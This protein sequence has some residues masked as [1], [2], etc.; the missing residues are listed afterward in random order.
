MAWLRRMW[1]ALRPS[2]VDRELHR[3]LAF[4]LAERVEE[5][6]ARGLTL[7]EATR[8]AQRQFGN[9][10]AQT[11]RTRAMDINA[12]VEGTIRNCRYALRTMGKTPA[13]TL[14]VI[15]TLA[16]GIGANSAVFSAINAVLLRPLAFPEGD[17]LVKLTQLHPGIPE[18]FVAP[19]RL[20]E[21]NRLNS[22][23]R[24]ITGYYTE[25]TSETSGDLP[26][27]VTR[28][29]VSPRFLQVLGIS[30]VIGRNFSPQEERYGGPSAVLLSYRFW[31][32]R[33]G[34]DPSVVGKRIRAAGLFVVVGVMP[35]SFDFPNRDVDLW[36][37][38]PPDAPYAQNREATWYTAIGRLKPGVSLAEAQANLAA[39]QASLGRQFPK[40]DAMK[41]VS[42]EPLKETTV[43]GVRRSLWLLFGA[44]SLLL[45]I[46]CVNIAALLLSRTAARQHETSVR[47]SLGASRVS[48]A[49]QL[50]M[51]VWMLALGG[52]AL[53]LLV[54]AGAA[55]VFRALAQNLPRVHEIGL[56]GSIVVYALVCALVVT[57]ACG[58]AP[59]IRG[60]RRTLA[61]SLAQ[62]GRS[63]VAGRSP[64]QFLLVGVQV[65]LSVTLLAG[66]GLLVRSFQELGRV[67]PGF[68]A[69]H[70]LTFHIS[71]TWAEA[72][73]QPA[74]QRT[75]R[76]LDGL[77]SLP[78]VEAVTTTVS[79][80]GVPGNYA[81]ET[82]TA[83]GRSETEPKMLAQARYVTPEYFAALRIPL[84]A[85]ELCRDDGN[86][87][88][89]MV[90]RT[91]ADRYLNGTAAI[92]RHLMQPVN[93]YIPAAEIRGIVGDA[94]ETGLD[95]VPPPTAYWCT[96]S[97][98]P[99]T[100]FLIR[101]HGEPKALAGAVRQ[102]VHELEP[103]RSVYDLTP[104]TEH[105]SDGYAENRLRTFLLAFFA[106]TAIALAS[107]GLYV[108]LSY[109]VN[110]RQREVALRLA[111]GSLRGQVLRQFL[112]QGVRVAVLGVLAGLA[113]AAVFTRMLT[114]MLFGVSATD[115]A[116]LT[117][118]VV[119]VL[120]V[121][122]AASLFPALRAARVE[123]MQALRDE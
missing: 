9:L 46:A 74:K 94:R 77:R 78:G 51:E 27:K 57:L 52:A 23:L 88:T 123:P 72:G 53:G 37:T 31:Q 111:L 11:E 18:P 84:V 93:P 28:A 22:T 25:D 99:T 109:H 3:E 112:G 87:L 104:L 81:I 65:A 95:R 79:L 48:V 1:N 41:S 96:G 34:G 70:V 86:R 54:A 97:M 45:L 92:G 80:P 60:T 4:H 62:G 69:P 13:F 122:G 107:V 120:A 38:T 89:V 66:A 32:R 59:A 68:D 33:F 83:E 100:F 55:Q 29:W 12:L 64:L 10:T 82:T 30:P 121:S 2:R 21:W 105:I 108:T 44:V 39:V 49:A 47:L 115:A 75:K 102:K 118:V 101:T 73:G 113:C 71:N 19:V 42:V 61:A 91:F 90:N 14:T 116:T 20:E 15:L 16:L 43:H 8:L 35:A 119:L 110:T 117:S 17:Q 76:I 114:S 5:L 98:Q 50:L 6:Q 58:A 106:L 103:R 36:S 7:A 63:Q 24:G 40:T 85:G 67:S 26:E 56:N